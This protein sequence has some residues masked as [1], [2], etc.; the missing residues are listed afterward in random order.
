MQNLCCGSLW[1]VN[2]CELF[3]IIIID[4]SRYDMHLLMGELRRAGTF[5]PN[6]TRTGDQYRLNHVID[7]LQATNY[8]RFC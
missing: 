6:I 8:T 7:E 5:Q 2:I 1:R 3:Y 4:S